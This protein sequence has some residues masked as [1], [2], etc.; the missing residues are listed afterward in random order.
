MSAV[1]G[2]SGGTLTLN[3]VSYRIV[4]MSA[5]ITQEAVDCSVLG[6]WVREFVAGPRTCTISATVECD[7]AIALSVITSLKAGTSSAIAAMSISFVASGSDTIS[8]SC[9][10]TSAQITTTYGDRE[11]CA[12]EMQVVGAF[13]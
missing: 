3:G 10:V 11:V 13:T 5:S 1:I 6:K 8:G 2:A 4:D 9:I 7:D 12:L